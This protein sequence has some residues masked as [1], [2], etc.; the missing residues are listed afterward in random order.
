MLEGFDKAFEGKA[1]L[2]IMSVLM[3][4]EQIDFIDIKALLDLSDGNLA[5]HLSYLEKLQYITILKSFKGKKPNT[6]ITISKLGKKAFLKHLEALE[7]LLG[8]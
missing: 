5:S 2:G 8:K 7:K 3:T 1:R 4:N 6:Q